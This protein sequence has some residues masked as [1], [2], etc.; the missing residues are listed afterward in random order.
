M[1]ENTKAVTDAGNAPRYFIETKGRKHYFKTQGE[2]SKVCAEVFAKTG[3]VL[4]IFRQRDKRTLYKTARARIS[5]ARFKAGDFVSVLYFG[6]GA[7]GT[8]W[9][10]ASK[11]GKANEAVACPQHHLTDF[12]L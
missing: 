5:C 7:N 12:C 1:T 11:S 8:H 6:I 9:F 3:I 10:L 4:G 2:A